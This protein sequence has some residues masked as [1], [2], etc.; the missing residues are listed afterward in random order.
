M[1]KQIVY[2]KKINGDSELTELIDISKNPP[3]IYCFCTEEIAKEILD[4]HAQQSKDSEWISVT[5]KYPDEKQTVWCYS[6]K[7]DNVFLG[8]YVYVINEGWFWAE[9]NG[10]IYASDGK[11]V[12]EC[13]MDDFDVSHWFPTPLLPKKPS[14]PS[15]LTT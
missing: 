4:F 2:A 13:E 7:L 6:E 8:E 15:R 12:S 10:V 14:N 1:E 3:K 11:I 5:E 9:S